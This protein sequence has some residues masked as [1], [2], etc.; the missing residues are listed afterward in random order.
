MPYVVVS[1]LDLTVLVDA[2]IRA[3]PVRGEQDVEGEVIVKIGGK[4]LL[5][6]RLKVGNVPNRTLVPAQADELATQQVVTAQDRVRQV[7]PED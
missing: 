3:E 7:T 5:R 1:V 2:R 4:G 6:G